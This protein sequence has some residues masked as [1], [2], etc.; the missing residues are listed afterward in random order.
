MRS[1]DYTEMGGGGDEF[2]TTHWSIIED[3]DASNDERDRALV[4]TLIEKYWKPVYCYL[5]HKG[6]DNEKSKDL[7]QGFFH[8][9]VLGRSLIQ[10][11]DQSKGRFRTFLLTAL[12]RFLI[13]VREYETT[14]KRIPKHKLVSLDLVDPP[15]LPESIS[16]STAADAFNYAWTSSLVEQVLR[17][18]ETACRDQGQEVYWIAFEKRVLQ[19]IMERTNPPS[20]REIC[21]QY[22]I[23][24]GIKASSMI[25]TV[26]RRFRAIL[27]RHLRNSVTSDEEEV[28]ELRDIMQFFPKFLL[29]KE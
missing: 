24:D 27:K 6:Y 29:Y 22:G 5:R 25:L 19:P 21:E 4:S 1:N 2:L 13:S 17:E 11:A 14:Q 8:E 7:T 3:V 18:V 15:K 26:K 16:R 28:D 10:K 12:N 23:E 9:V 20:L